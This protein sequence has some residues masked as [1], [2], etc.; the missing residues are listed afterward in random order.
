MSKTN[1]PDPQNFTPTLLMEF[2]ETQMT[3]EKKESLPTEKK[4]KLNAV[5]EYY[6][7]LEDEEKLTLFQEWFS[8]L[9]QEEQKHFFD[10]FKSNKKLEDLSVEEKSGINE[11]LKDEY[12]IVESQNIDDDDQTE[13]SALPTSKPT[14]LSTINPT[15]DP[16][17]EPSRRSR[18]PNVKPTRIETPTS[19]PTVF[20]FPSKRPNH[21]PID[22]PSSSPAIS[23]QGSSHPI[24]INTQDLVIGVC[25]GVSFLLLA[26]CCIGAFCRNKGVKISESKP[27]TMVAKEENLETGKIKVEMRLNHQSAATKLDGGDISVIKSGR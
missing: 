1:I 8:G 25:A 5:K 27:F 10:R 22:R 9:D 26:G 18:V 13:K 3:S 16:T 21:S 12:R 19:Q 4:A 7:S 6:K 24:N 2:V 11:V 23:G 20:S 17:L 15:L 14:S